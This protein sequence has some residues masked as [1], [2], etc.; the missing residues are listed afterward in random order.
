MK[1]F[2]SKENK[3]EENVLENEI[4]RY[5]VNMKK[6]CHSYLLDVKNYFNLGKA[7]KHSIF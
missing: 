1:T 5:K 3:N 4:E 6:I 2:R 7:K